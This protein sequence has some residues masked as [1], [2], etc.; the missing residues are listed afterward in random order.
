[1]A[2]QTGNGDF[3]G[4]DPG[5]GKAHQNP[6]Q[7]GTGGGENGVRHLALI[8]RNVL[9]FF[10][11]GCQGAVRGSENQ[12]LFGPGHGYI[13]NPQFLA[14]GLQ[15][16][17]PSDGLLFQGGHPQTAVQIHPV[18]PQAQIRVHENGGV[19]VLLVESFSHSRQKYNGEFQALALMD[20][21]DPHRIRLLVHRT[22]LPEVRIVPL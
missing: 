18:C 3:P 11:F 19:G 21:H 13:E 20:A 17:P 5:A 22:G 2:H 10:Q 9:P 16:H 12:L 15:L 4:L 14:H 6:V 7:E 8:E 1:M